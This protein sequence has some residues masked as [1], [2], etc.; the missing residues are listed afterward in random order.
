MPPTAITGCSGPR[1]SFLGSERHCPITDIF[2][3]LAARF[4]FDEPAFKASDHELMDD[5]VDAGHPSFKGACPSAIP[6]RAAPRVSST[7]G[8]PLALF[9]THRPATPSGKVELAS[10]V[11]AGR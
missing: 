8:R 2:R 4:G 9:D 1:P 3:R 11:L 5:A 7:D 6:I 10:D